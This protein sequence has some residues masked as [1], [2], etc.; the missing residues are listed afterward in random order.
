MKKILIVVIALASLSG[1]GDEPHADHSYVTVTT[2]NY[3]CTDGSNVSIEISDETFTLTGTCNRILVNGGNNKL[4]I[5]AAK[6]VDIHGVNNIV[7]MVAIDT[8]RARQH[9]QIQ[10]GL[11]WEIDGCGRN[12]RQQYAHPIKLIFGS[13]LH[14]VIVRSD[15]IGLVG[16]V[17]E[18]ARANRRSN[19]ALRR[20]P[21]AENGTKDGVIGR[22]FVDS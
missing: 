14:L 17:A 2:P 18:L 6:R 19:N 8:L 4:M 10:E 3:H 7:E 9:D 22:R 12:R 13:G 20:V 1:C 15:R 16:G 11:N 21:T 5:E